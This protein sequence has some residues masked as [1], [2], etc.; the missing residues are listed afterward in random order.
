MQEFALLLG[1]V[2]AEWILFYPRMTDSAGYFWPALKRTGLFL[3]LAIAARWAIGWILVQS[4][5]GVFDSA[6][7][8]SWVWGFVAGLIIVVFPASFEL[9]LDKKATTKVVSN[10]LVQLLLRL[11]LLVGQIMRSAVQEL[12]EQDNYDCQNSREWWNFGLSGEKINRRLRILYEVSKLDIACKRRQPELLRHYANISSGQK[13]Y[14][15]VAHMGRNRLWKAIQEP[16]L[17]PPPGCD[18]DGRERRRRVGAKEER[19]LPDPNAAYSRIY[20]D[21]DLRKSILEGRAISSRSSNAN[22]T[23]P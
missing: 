6:R 19:R 20:D 1:I 16:P 8:T 15:L 2:I 9:F 14:L 7:S 11:N 23:D 4:F 22:Y 5:L 13:F 10:T 12:K 3:L 21:E 18:W 17:P